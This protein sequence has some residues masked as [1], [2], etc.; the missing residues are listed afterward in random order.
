MQRKIKSFVSVAIITFSILSCSGGEMD[1]KITS[2]NTIKDV[3][4]TA[5]EKLSTKKIYFGHQSVGYD[6]IDGIQDLKK[7]FPSIELNIV[8]TTKIEDLSAGA[9]LHSKVGQNKDPKSKIDDFSRIINSGFGGT[10]DAATLKFCFVDIV[11]STD[12]LKVFEDYK[13]EVEK[14]KQKYPKLTLIHF[15]APLTLRQTGWKVSIKKLIGR[16][17]GGYAENV[18]RAEYN[19]LLKK[20]FQGKD[21]L[22]DIAEIESTYPDGTRCSFDAD[23]KTYYSLVPEYT[24]DGG[25]LNEN[26]RK[27]VAEQL[28]LLLVNLK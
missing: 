26:G 9:L 11:S 10:L 7:E 8:E 21:P 25:H 28:L 20:E 17:I 1:R 24:H 16:P 13:V 14:L 12:S 27:K 2:Y 3:P 6:I 22:F 5:W 19:E 23:G 4:A 18:K 15:T